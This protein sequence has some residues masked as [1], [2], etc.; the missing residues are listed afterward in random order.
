MKDLCIAALILMLAGCARS[1]GTKIDAMQLSAL[2]PGRTS[3]ADVERQFGSPTGT[4]LTSE[5]ITTLS[6][7]YV[8][9]SKTD[10]FPMI[11]TVAPDETDKK[12]TVSL[13]FN[14]DGILKSYDRTFA[15]AAA[16]NK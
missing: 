11:E 7:A 8:P 1:H 12:Q 10:A 14:P 2:Q 9:P 6:Y 16:P 3:M 13:V 15:P 5:G 4:I